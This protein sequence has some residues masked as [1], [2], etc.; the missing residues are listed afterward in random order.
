MVEDWWAVH[1]A[2]CEEGA[3]AYIDPETGFQ[4]F[5]RLGLL[6]RGR[7]CG[8]GCRHCPYHHESVSIEDRASLIKQ[9]A[10]L[11]E[12]R[13]E[14]VGGQ[15]RVCLLFWSGG[16]DSYL[17]YRRLQRESDAEIVL[18]T[19][20]DLT[21]GNI[22]HQDLHIETVVAQANHLGVPL[23]GV[24]LHSGRSYLDHIVDALNLAQ[25]QQLAFGDLHLEHIRE[26]REQTFGSDPRTQE[27]E[28]VFPVWQ[29]PYEE[30]VTDLMAAEIKC[31]VS[32]VTV[33]ELGIAV[34]D[35]F[36][37]EFLERLPETVDAFGE[38]GEFHTEVSFL[39]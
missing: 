10:W 3:S 4:V 39:T 25:P 35:R 29:V 15:T 27:L 36:D 19:S 6:E 9:P 2:A 12:A 13:T 33:P 1:E 31:T 11:T 34:G 7:C 21:T 26:W 22:A 37:N 28:L 24:P 38:N 23:I 18:L 14:L 16:K 17:A 8:A 32:A 5:T 30:L 20:F